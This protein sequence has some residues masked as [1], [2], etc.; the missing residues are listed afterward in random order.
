MS[1]KSVEEAASAFLGAV[2]EAADVKYGG[3]PMFQQ[4]ATSGA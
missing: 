2:K 1:R 4:T 3:L